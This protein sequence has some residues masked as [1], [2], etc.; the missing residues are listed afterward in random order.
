[1]EFE[2]LQQAMFCVG[3]TY[4]MHWQGWVRDAARSGAMAGTVNVD[5]CNPAVF[6]A[7]HNSGQ[8]S[9]KQISRLLPASD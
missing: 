7:Y 5:R 1:M 4:F 8:H 9:P 2:K 6:L 3:C